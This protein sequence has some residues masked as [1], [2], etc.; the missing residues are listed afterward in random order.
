MKKFIK[1]V[2]TGPRGNED[3]SFD[4]AKSMMDF[5]LDDAI[6]D[7]E[8]ASFL[9][10]WRLKPETNVEFSGALSSIYAHSKKKNLENSF[11]LGF[12]FDGKNDSPYLFPLVGKLLKSFGI[13]LI[14]TGD[15]RIPAKNGVTVKM[16]HEALLKD[17]KLCALTS[18]YY[19]YDRSDY[20]E[21]LSKLSNMR[22]LI[23]MRTGLNTLE[24][25]SQIANSDYG[26]SGVFHKPYVEKYAA[27]F[28]DHFKGILFVGGNEGSPE[29]AKKSKI[30]IMTKSSIHEEIIDP[31]DFEIEQ[32]SNEKEWSK[33]DQ[34][35]ILK[36]PNQRIIKLSYLNASLYM[37]IIKP[38]KS[39]GEYFNMFQEIT[40]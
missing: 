8:K 10:G 23:G 18:N 36:N 22:N 9:I 6:S 2:A 34:L 15:E 17:E 28:N 19:Y 27:I 29:L 7:V 26:A 12:P 35:N 39:I 33:D 5:M 14:I 21:G 11:E 30:W 1:K 32:E 24:K 37:H 13:N 3:L 20:C 4:E 25:F 38:E 40:L 16:L 31:T